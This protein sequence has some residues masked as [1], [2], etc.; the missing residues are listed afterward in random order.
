GPPDS[1]RAP[2]ALRRATPRRA[3]RPGP[4]LESL[5][6]ALMESPICVHP[7]RLH[8]RGLRLSRRAHVPPAFR[9]GRILR[10]GPR[11]RGHWTG[12]VRSTR[13]PPPLRAHLVRVIGGRGHDPRPPGGPSVGRRVHNRGAAFRIPAVLARAPS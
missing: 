8:V 1:R 12:R 5:S 9:G 7:P 6:T 4:R 3:A 11:P 13:G 10:V 2:P